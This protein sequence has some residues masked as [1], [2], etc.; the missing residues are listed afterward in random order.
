MDVETWCRVSP[1][2]QQTGASTPCE[3]SP[4]RC[5][6]VGFLATSTRPLCA[7][8]PVP[9]RARAGLWAAVGAEAEAGSC[10]GGVGTRTRGPL[11]AGAGGGY[12]GSLLSAQPL[13]GGLSP[14]L[15]L[16][17]LQQW[18]MRSG[19]GAQA[20]WGRAGRSK[21]GRNDGTGGAALRGAARR[22]GGGVSGGHC[23][24][25]TGG[26]VHCRGV[27]HGRVELRGGIALR[28]GGCTAYHARGGGECMGGLNCTEG[29]HCTGGIALHCIA[30]HGRVAWAGGGLPCTSTVGS[31]AGDGLVALGGCSVLEGLHCT[32]LEPG[33]GPQPGSCLG[34]PRAAVPSLKYEIIVIQMIPFAKKPRCT[35]KICK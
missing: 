25:C 26:G 29:L 31:G 16:Y 13:R 3:R 15:A 17:W 10:P 4:P 1:G 12:E 19:R 33:A 5:T 28:E 11:S 24:H 30:L 8:P 35:A 2:E 21:C 20:Q 18:P 14:S 27:L 34:L 23:M 7:P 9:R 32:A 6:G 22:G